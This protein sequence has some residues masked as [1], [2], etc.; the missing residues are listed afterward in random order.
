MLEGRAQVVLNVREEARLVRRRDVRKGEVKVAMVA[1][2][3]IR[4][5][6]VGGICQ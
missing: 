4:A 1:E 5:R 2:K 3:V 6:D